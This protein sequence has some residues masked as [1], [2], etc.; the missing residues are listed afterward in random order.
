MR[1]S[2]HSWSPRHIYIV[3]ILASV[4]ILFATLQYTSIFYEALISGDMHGMPGFARIAVPDTFLYLDLFKIFSQSD[5]IFVASNV[6]NSQGPVSLWYLA[7]GNWY[8]IAAI[9]SFLVFLSM[10]FVFRIIQHFEIKFSKLSLTFIYIG[11]T[12]ILVYYS[13]GSLK[14]IPSLLG[15]LG[16]FYYYLKKQRI[17][18]IFFTLVLIFFR[19]QL[20]FPITA[21]L[22]I[23]KIFRHHPL[24]ISIVCLLIIASLYPLISV[25]N[26][27]S[28]NA[29]EIFRA[30]QAYT[31]GALVE[32]VRNRIPFMSAVAVL[33]RVFQSIFEPILTL[34]KN[35]T[36]YESDGFS[37]YICYNFFQ[38]LVLSPYWFLTIVGIIRAFFKRKQS[39]RDMDRIYAFLA[40]Y[41]I[42]VGGFSFISHRYLFPIS[43]LI[44]I[45]GLFEIHRQRSVRL[46][47][48]VGLKPN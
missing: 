30:D 1:T 11:I 25:L 37:I 22:V 18:W 33:V 8:V 7:N 3:S 2:R 35:P 31:I 41:M 6:K 9:N 17:G 21:F 36:F 20:I 46:Q 19:Y 42:T 16:F 40:C 29:T 43:G 45:G 5:S 24:K 14:E 13:I 28:N 26:I 10:V 4:L 38:N 23:D 27:F 47:L 15:L 48:R 32:E 44:L 39:N 12:P 34:I